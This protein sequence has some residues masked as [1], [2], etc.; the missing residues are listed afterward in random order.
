[1]LHGTRRHHANDIQAAGLEQIDVEFDPA[2]L[3]GTRG[4]GQFERVRCWAGGPV[5][6]SAGRLARMWC[7][8]RW[9]QA[10]LR[11]AT[12]RFVQCALAAEPVRQPSWLSAVR[13]SLD[14]G[15][16]A[17][18]EQLARPLELHPTWLA[19]AYRSASGEGIRETV[20]RL[21]VQHAT[22]LLRDSTLPLA[23]IAVDAG[24]CDQS[25]M[26]RAFRRLLGRTP[27]EVRV[28]GALLRCGP[29]QPKRIS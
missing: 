19:Q 16:V 20:R 5:A 24:F 27:L 13:Q 17:T 11:H 14:V 8:P 26:N 9:S 15:A 25:H 12:A 28:E 21:R 10:Q 29:D 6:A 23:Q 22:G 2:W 4:F 3:N 18:A 7:E 1:V